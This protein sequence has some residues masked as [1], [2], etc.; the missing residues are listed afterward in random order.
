MIEPG[1]PLQP[2][3]IYNSNRELL[4]GL[5]R[6]DGLEPTTWPTLP[7]D[8]AR[9]A[10]MLQDAASSF[11]V[12]ITCGAVSAGEK[13]HIPAVSYTHLDVYKRQQDATVLGAVLD[14]GKALVIAINKWDGRSDYERQQAEAL[15]SRKLSFV[16]WA[17]NVRISALHGS[18]LRELFKAIHRAHASATKVFSTAEV[19]RAVEAAVVALSLIHI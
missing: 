13:D 10:A 1:L 6:A 3:E 19:T 7:D 11:D 9:I 2:G 18:G 14:A 15:V 16:E 8:P 12:V 5:L 4:T 17:E